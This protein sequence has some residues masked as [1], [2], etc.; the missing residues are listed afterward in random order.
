M[1]KCLTAY[2]SPSDR[3]PL[4]GHLP[5]ASVPL[6]SSP[7]VAGRRNEHALGD[8]G[9]HGAAP[10]LTATTARCPSSPV[11]EV[12]RLAVDHALHV[13]RIA[14][15]GDVYVGRGVVELGDVLGGHVQV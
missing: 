6:T 10:R 4:S 8:G 13:L 9:G 1:R 5:H 12:V 2:S 15:P 11:R 14:L 3:S 7:L